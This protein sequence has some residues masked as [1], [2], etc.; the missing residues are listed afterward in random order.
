[1]G[2]DNVSHIMSPFT[3]ETV[4]GLHTRMLP[5]DAPSVVVLPVLP[6]LRNI[7]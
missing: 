5:M 1:M 3:P 6:C 7:R 2:K 4:K